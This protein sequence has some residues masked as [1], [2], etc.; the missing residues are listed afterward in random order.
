VQSKIKNLK[1]KPSFKALEPG[2]RNWLFFSCT[3]FCL[4]F[5]SC[6]SLKIIP[7]EKI[8]KDKFSRTYSMDFASFHPKLNSALQEY[9][10]KHKGN[11]FRVVRLGS[12]GVMIRGYFKSDNHQERF[13]TEITVK[14]ADQKKTR[15]E[16][17]LFANNPTVS[18]DSFEKASQELFQIIA[19]GTGVSP[20]G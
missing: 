7:E 15:L 13:S 16:I 19:R 18:P 6:A 8:V 5:N 10:Q 11:S 14:P 20:Q 1:L 9:A 4:L 17:K 3:V 12:D 2:L